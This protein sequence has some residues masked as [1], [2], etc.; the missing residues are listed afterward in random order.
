[1]ADLYKITMDVSVKDAADDV[2]VIGFTLRE[3]KV[4]KEDTFELERK[5]GEVLMARFEKKMAETKP[6]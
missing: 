5:L 4:S 1:M 3:G 2:E 6:V